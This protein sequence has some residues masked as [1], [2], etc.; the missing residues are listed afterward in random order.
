MPIL[1]STLFDTLRTE[2]LGL[3]WKLYLWLHLRTVYGTD[4]DAGNGDWVKTDNG[5]KAY[6]TFSS[7][8]GSSIGAASNPLHK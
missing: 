4:C 6:Q 5:F 8:A 1:P 7:K 2:I 3:S